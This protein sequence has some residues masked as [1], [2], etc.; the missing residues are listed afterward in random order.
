[1]TGP[2]AGSL[3]ANETGEVMVH[4]NALGSDTDTL[5]AYV[6]FL[7]NNEE[8]QMLVPVHLFV[9]EPVSV[10]ERGSGKA[11]KRGSMAVWPNPAREVL[12]VECL[13]LNEKQDYKLCILNSSGKLIREYNVDEG[14]RNI[15]INIQSFTPGIYFAALKSG[16]ARVV[17]KKFIVSR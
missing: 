16:S 6:A 8:D 11:G 13:M 10:D 4:F 2:L 12:N 7:Y 15:Q 5:F 3:N 1:M 14:N 17:A 9:Q